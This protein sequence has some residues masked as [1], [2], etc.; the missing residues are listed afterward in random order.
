ME[1]KKLLII[2]SLSLSLA[3]CATSRGFNRTALREEIGQKKTVDEAEIRK[4]LELKP[5]LPKPF[6]IGVYLQNTWQRWRWSESDKEKLLSWAKNL[7][8]K[9]EVSD[10]FIINSDLAQDAQLKSIRLAAARHGA[11]AVLVVSGIS[12]IDSYNTKWGWTYLALFPMLF[13]PGDQ[14]DAI[15]IGR[16]SLWDVKNQYLYLT[17]ESEGTRTDTVP[18][19]S[20]N[21]RALIESTKS[22]AISKLSEQIGS[23]AERFLQKQKGQ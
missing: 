15:F 12:D 18:L 3:A 8:I 2:F 10:I 17:A 1:I 7:K 5:Q 23:S 14:I 9:K 6:K 11:D 4:T 19:I 20:R 16:A 13:A 22:E 21:E